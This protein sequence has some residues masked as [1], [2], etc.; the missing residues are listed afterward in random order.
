MFESGAIL[1]HLA[2]RSGRLLPADERE[3]AGRWSGRCS[4][5][6]MSG[7]PSAS[8]GTG[9][10]SPGKPA[11]VL[12]RFEREARRV[13]G[14]LDGRLARHPHLA[15]DAYGIADVM[16]WPWIRAAVEG[17]GVPIDDLPALSRW[18]AAVGE[19]PAVR[20]GL[21]VPVCLQRPRP[22]AAAPTLKEAAMETLFI[23][24]SLVA[25]G[26]LAVQAG[27]NAQLSKAVGSPFGATTLQL[28]VGAAAL[29]L[30]ALL[31]G[32]LVALAELPQVPWWH[33]AGGT[34]SAFYVVSTILLFPRLGAVV[35]VGLFIAGQMLAS[36]A[37]DTFG[38][39]GRARTGLGPATL[40]GTALV[41]L[42]AAGDRARPGGRRIRAQP[43]EARLDRA[44]ARRRRRAAGAGGGERPAAAGPRRALRGRRGQL[45][46]GDPRHG[47]RAAAAVLVLR[48][49]RP[50]LDGA[51]PCRGGAGS[52][53]SRARP[54]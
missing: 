44:G 21:R 6:R 36:L 34:A 33:A 2:R 14:V 3:R 29:S 11:C 16:T 41:L 52:A 47:G 19:R 43:P 18:Y 26:L 38:A 51:R 53:A 39:A 7:R 28:S 1:H 24:V 8:S 35:S 32:S 40:G 49:P 25:G 45:P 27:A 42:G 5:R 46:G 31:T 54:T 50:K 12:A 48:A 20:R 15:G 4:R 23:P 37:L 17:I 30:V 13:F 10:S 9:G 22:P